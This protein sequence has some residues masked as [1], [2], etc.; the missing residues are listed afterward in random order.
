[1]VER[2]ENLEE[3]EELLGKFCKE[4]HPEVKHING[5][6]LT[7]YAVDGGGYCCDD[8]VT[9]NIEDGEFTLDVVTKKNPKTY[10]ATETK[11]FRFKLV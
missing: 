5:K 2:T 3:L 6:N 10:R 11:S 9:F 7:L 1:M 4:E 8:T